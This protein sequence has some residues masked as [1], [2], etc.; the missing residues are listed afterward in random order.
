MGQKHAPQIFAMDVNDRRD[1]YIET[2]EE[3]T[4][5]EKRVNE[6]QEKQ[7]R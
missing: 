2:L 5:M 1:E 7:Q 4:A 3:K 6:K